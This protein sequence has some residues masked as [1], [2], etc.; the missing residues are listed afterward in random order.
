[1]KARGYS[2]RTIK[3]YLHWIKYF[4]VFNGKKHPENLG[5]EEVSEFLSHLVVQREVSQSTQGIA[6]NALVFLYNKFLNQPLGN[7]SEF[8]RSKRV[9]KLPT[10][11]TH[12]EVARLLAQLQGVSLLMASIAY[13]SGLRRMELLRLRLKDLDLDN[14]QI[15]VWFGKGGKHRFTTLAPELVP[16][17]QHQMQRVRLLLNEDK[18]VEGF[19]G[20]T[21]PPALSRKYPKARFD[22][23]WQYLF[24]A[25]RLCVHPDTGRMHRHHLHETAL[26]RQ[27]RF[28][29]K[30]AGIE[31]TVSS[32]TLRHSFATHLL[33][34][35][36]DIRTVQEQLGHF[37]VKT[38][39]IYTHVLKRGARGVVSPLSKL[40]Q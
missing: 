34:S 20:S 33:Q 19:D 11:L 5:R 2:P 21:M 22:P 9:A 17:I 4:I 23:P 26:S 30:R 29:G 16:Q 8:Q 40:M 1:M 3:T 15:Q 31:K 6:L 27:L 18:N 37:D 10:V 14:L 7:L 25:T 13:G 24:P 36:A 28:A 38:T 39:E 12:D 32:H 35:G